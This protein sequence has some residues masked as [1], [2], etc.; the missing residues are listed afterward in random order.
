MASK[1]ELEDIIARQTAALKAQM[2]EIESLRA[3]NKR[4]NDAIANNHD[5]L[6]VLQRVY[7]DPASPVSVT[8]K[9]ASEAI[10]FERPRPPQT[11]HIG[12]FVD[13]FAERLRLKRLGLVD[14]TPDD[15]DGD[16][17]AAPIVDRSDEA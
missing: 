14:V 9:A 17:D 4:L 8:L 16:D 3:E 7:S 12:L 15:A 2:V 1:A 11:S 5:A 13:D 6:A 10:N